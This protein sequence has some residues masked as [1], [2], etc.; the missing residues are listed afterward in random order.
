MREI[1][2][3]KNITE[4][5]KKNGMTQEQLAAAINVSPQAVSKWE[6][7]ACQPDFQTI[8][9]LAEHFHVSIDYLFY[10]QDMVYEDIYE[11]IFKLT[12]K[13][14]QMSVESYETALKIFAHAHHGIS[15]GNLR[16][17]GP[18]ELH[19][20]PIHISSEGGISLLGGN[21]FGAVVTRQYFTHMNRETAEFAGKI[22]AI[23]AEKHTGE[24][25]MAIVSM[26]DISFSELEEKLAMPKEELRT[27]L[28]K[29]I[30]GGLVVEKVSKH[31]VLG[32]TYDIVDMYHSCLC[33]L[34]A[35]MQMQK[36]SLNG[37]SCCMG[38]GDYPIGLA[39]TEEAETEN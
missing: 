25:C 13:K 4:L 39:G 37:I 20:Q 28:D 5:R 34:F 31:K 36:D 3:A 12:E 17:R 33:L 30:A 1:S 35:I 38:Y 29:L 8:P 14:E 7:G 23:L 16:G 27:A 24:V 19:D 18:V 15:C 2:I 11:K 22:C 32:T 26:S 9:T 21:G 10:G 6:T